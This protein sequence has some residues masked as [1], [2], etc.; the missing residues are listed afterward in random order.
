MDKVEALAQQI[1]EREGCVLYDVEFVGSGTGRTLRVYI[2]KE[3]EPVG[4]E[5]CSRVSQALNLQLDVD[6]VVP[7]GAY[8]LE[9]SSPGLERKLKKE[10]HYQKATGQKVDFKLN[11]PL[12]SFNWEN[13]KNKSIKRFKG[14]ITQVHRDQVQVE[15]EGTKGFIP[16]TSIEKASVCFEITKGKKK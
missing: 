16:M 4:I 8:H 3:N 12:G 1:S 10:W 11:E 15:C 14:I 6:D 5:D 9:V 13:L 2:D 7:G